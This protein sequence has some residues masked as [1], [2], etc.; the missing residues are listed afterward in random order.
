MLVDRAVPKSVA[1]AVGGG[2]V[3]IVTMVLS[4]IR[5]LAESG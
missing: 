1:A 4:I 3:A 2:I 5:C